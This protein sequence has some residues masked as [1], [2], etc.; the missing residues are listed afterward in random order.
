MRF[1]ALHLC[2]ALLSSMPGVA[3]AQAETPPATPDKAPPPPAGTA[4]STGGANREEAAKH[5]QAAKA[6]YK[7]GKYLEALGEFRKAYDLAPSAALT[8]NVARCHERLSQY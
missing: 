6:F 2:A 7:E 1:S 8:Y 3:L 5:D 4:T